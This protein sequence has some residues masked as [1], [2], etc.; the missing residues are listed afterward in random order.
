[1]REEFADPPSAVVAPRL[2]HDAQPGPPLLVAARGIRAEHLDASRRPRPEPFHDLERGGLA[3]AVRAEQGQHLSLTRLEGHVVQD[4][5]R[6]V[7][8]AQAVH[9]EHDRAGG[10]Y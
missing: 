2:K 10:R 6:A 9:V 1:M 4:V 7:T 5:G 8:H 3:R